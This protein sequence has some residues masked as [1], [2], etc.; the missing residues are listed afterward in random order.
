MA[1]TAN[2]TRRSSMERRCLS[3]SSKRLFRKSTRALRRVVYE[4]ECHQKARKPL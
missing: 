4:A 1:S 2:R 3:K